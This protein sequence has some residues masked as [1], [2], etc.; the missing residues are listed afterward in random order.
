MVVIPVI[1]TFELKPSHFVGVIS[2]PD[3]LT[4]NKYFVVS[5]VLAR[6]QC[7]VLKV[8]PGHSLLRTVDVSKNCGAVF[9]GT[10]GYIGHLRPDCVTRLQNRI[11]KWGQKSTEDV[12]FF[13]LGYLFEFLTTVIFDP[14]CPKFDKTKN[15]YCDLLM[16]Y[17]R[18]LRIQYDGNKLRFRDT[19][20]HQIMSLIEQLQLEE[21]APEVI[22]ESIKNWCW[23]NILNEIK[24]LKFAHK[25]FGIGDPPEHR[26][27]T[28]QSSKSRN[29]I[30]AESSPFVM[31]SFVKFNESASTY[32]DAPK[33]DDDK[34][35]ETTLYDVQKLFTAMTEHK[36]Q[37]QEQVSL[38]ATSLEQ[39]QVIEL[40]LAS[41]EIRLAR[42]KAKLDRIESMMSD[43]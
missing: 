43:S 20:R 11:Q 36:T 19:D 41:V 14:R 40:K 2:K 18:P 6:F 26:L 24:A 5:E 34:Q 33:Y 25:Y 42:I 15:D 22:V 4:T 29:I 38:K 13:P 39:K 9:D 31:S 37:L 23:S 8:L 16:N 27:K 28:Y 35:P 1:H 30:F 17:A 21:R 32:H 12:L 10:F 3:L 7:Q